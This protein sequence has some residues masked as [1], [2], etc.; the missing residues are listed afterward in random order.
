MSAE[1][2]GDVAAAGA[3]VYQCVHN[4]VLCPQ[5]CVHEL[6]TVEQAHTYTYVSTR[7]CWAHMWTGAGGAQVLPSADQIH[8]NSSTSITNGIH[9][10]ACTNPAYQL[11]QLSFLRKPCH[12]TEWAEPRHS[13]AISTLPNALILSCARV[14][15]FF[16]VF[17]NKALVIW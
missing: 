8:N 12:Q 7:T 5:V 9:T 4:L 13:V 14:I 1:C 11:I 3:C 15:E 10:C 2:A 16:T 6:L 17:G